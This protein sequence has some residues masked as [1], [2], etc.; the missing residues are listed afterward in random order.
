ML[1]LIQLNGKHGGRIGVVTGNSIEL[2]STNRTIYGLA[3]LCLSRGMSITQCVTGQ[4]SGETVDYEAAYQGTG[5]WQV[6]LP[7]DHPD[8]SARVLVSGTGLTHMASVKNRD[9]MHSSAQNVTDSVKMYQLGLEGGRPAA[10]KIGTSPEWF[11]KGTGS[12]LKAHNQPLSIP[13]FAEDGGEEP[14]IAG[15]YL[16]DTA[17]NPRRIG[18]CQGNEFSDHLFEKRNYLYL[19]SSKLRDC[20]IGPELIVG[21]DF[22]HVTGEVS[23]FRKGQT[24]WSQAIQTGEEV[25]CHSLANMEHH[26]FKF[27]GHRRPGDVH[28]HYYGADAFSFG[29]GILL[30]DG[31]TMQVSFNG[32]GRPLRNP[33]KREPVSDAPVI[34]RWI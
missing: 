13:W 3:M 26:H 25:M 10:G 18:F 8:D 5:E 33:V 23:I 1:R 19:A 7:I 32:F 2:L 22:H 24:L 6:G 15:I 29:A 4:L 20:A 31:D 9:A 34:V 14:E 12:V 16:I 27:P 21:A 11:Y 17:G 28:V 30:Q